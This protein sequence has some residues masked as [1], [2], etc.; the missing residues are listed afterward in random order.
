MTDTTK[1]PELFPDEVTV[2]YPPGSISHMSVCNE[3]LNKDLPQKQY[4]P[5]DQYD[6]RAT[7]LLNANNDLLE[8][9]RKAEAALALQSTREQ[10][11][12]KIIHDIHGMARRYADGR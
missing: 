11:L 3:L 4:V 12:E 1:D 2:F 7:E 9:A 6:R 10:A 5:F 8:R